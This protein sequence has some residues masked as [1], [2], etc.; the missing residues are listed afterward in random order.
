MTSPITSKFSAYRG[1]GNACPVCNSTSGRCSSQKYQLTGKDRQTINTDKIYCMDG[2]G[3]SGNPDYH[4]FNDTRDGQWG[5]YILLADWSKHCGTY[6][7]SSVADKEQWAAERQQRRQEIV[8]LEQKRQGDSLGG[9]ER[10]LA[11][12]AIMSQ[13]SLNWIDRKDLLGRGFTLDQINKIGFKS[14]DRWQ[15]L[16]TPVNNRFPGVDLHGTKLNS[17]IGGVLIPIYSI[18]GEILAFQ[19]RNRQKSQEKRY[20]WLSSAWEKNRPNG[21]SPKMAT[22]ENPLSFVDP[23]KLGIEIRANS[24]GFAEGS[25]AKPNLAAIKMGQRVIGAVGGQWLSSPRLLKEGLKFWNADQIDLYM[26]KDDL[27]NPQVLR[28]WVKLHVQLTEWG[29]KPQLVWFVNADIDESKDESNKQILDINFLLS[30]IEPVRSQPKPLVPW[31]RQYYHQSK[32]FT[33]NQTSTSRY[34]DWNIPNTMENALVGIK[35]ALGTGKTEILKKLAVWAKERGL[36]LLFIGYRNNLL[37]QTCDRIPD[38]MHVVDEDRI[39]LGSDYHKALCHHSAGLLD[40]ENMHNKIVIFDECVS[41]LQDVLTS[42]L[43]AGRQADGRDSRQVRLNHLQTLIEHSY[44]VVVLDAYLS[45]TEVNFLQQI[46]SFDQTHKIENTFKN[47]MNVQMCEHKSQLDLAIIEDALAGLRILVTATTQKQCQNLE[48][49]LTRAGVNPDLICR[50]DSTTD[51]ND[52]IKLFF[53]NPKAFLKEFQPQVVIMSPTAESGISIDLP[54]Y[55]QTHYH[56]HMGNLGILSGLQFLGRYRDF[57]APRVIFCEV[58]GRVDDGNSSSVEKWVRDEFNQQISTDIQLSLD[59]LKNPQMVEDAAQVLTTCTKEQNFW[60]TLAHKHKASLNEEMKHLREL[61]IEAMQADGYQVMVDSGTERCGDTQELMSRVEIE[62][63][64]VESKRLYEAID[65]TKTQ[66]DSIRKNISAN[67]YDRLIAAKYYLTQQYLPGIAQTPSYCADLIQI[68]KFKCPGLVP[69]LEN[70]FY[71]LNPALAQR[72][73]LAAWLPIVSC[74][75]TWLPDRTAK[76]SLALISVARELGIHQLLELNFGIEAIERI[77]QAIV[78]SKA[79]RSALRLTLNPNQSVEPIALFAKVVK[80][81]GLKLT[82]HKGNNL[83]SLVPLAKTSKTLRSAPKYDLLTP[84][85]CDDIRS[86]VGSEYHQGHVKM[87]QLADLM[88]ELGIADGAGRMRLISGAARHLGLSVISRRHRTKIDHKNRVVRVY[89]FFAPNPGQKDMYPVS[90]AIANTQIYADGNLIDLA[91]IYQCVS[92]RLTALSQLQMDKIIAWQANR[93]QLQSE[94]YAPIQIDAFADVDKIN[95]P[96]DRSGSPLFSLDNVKSVAQS[97]FCIA[98]LP[99]TE[100]KAAWTE[101]KS[102]IDPQVIKAGL[103]LLKGKYCFLSERLSFG[104]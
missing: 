49:A 44:S 83:F 3:G 5:I 1:K 18:N 98:K 52:R 23:Q 101:Y 77:A 43:T 54:G 90:T 9:A 12:R 59:V 76:S 7:E 16:T 75:A 6:Q 67:E 39:L 58:R 2:V 36:E 13:L 61:F 50:I 14:I 84:E 74:E 17:S 73:R 103:E 34:L 53:R 8:E 37:R 56:F 24:I 22:G 29:Y 99:M 32:A 95:P 21:S 60:L 104:F 81:I 26:D 72:D 30:K 93:I 70:Y 62:R 4:Y 33:P 89:S 79:Y 97:L 63:R 57:S 35:S 11:A 87:Q 71:F 88:V 10:D 86:L 65:I 66:Y 91:D 40:P 38:L 48:K 25:G 102:V 46:R 31:A 51:R 68:I 85:L 96:C 55:F 42:K 41:V 82:E 92:A 45:D 19:V 69:S 64:V 80:K 28:R 78:A 47:F 100:L 27:T 20:L 15:R 94:L